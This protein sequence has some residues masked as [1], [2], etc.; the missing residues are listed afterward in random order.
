MTRL[1]R[2]IIR[3]KR[4]GKVVLAGVVLVSAGLGTVLL[5]GLFLARNAGEDGLV[6][7]ALL[8]LGLLAAM[9]IFSLVLIRKQHRMLDEA[10]EDLRSLVKGETAI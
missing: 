9:N 2:R 4:R 6:A 5:Q 3:S 10:R 1:D 7:R 8:G